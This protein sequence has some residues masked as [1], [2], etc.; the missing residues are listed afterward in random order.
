[1]HLA[2]LNNSVTTAGPGG[3]LL[4]TAYS[5][6]TGGIVFDTHGID[7]MILDK[8]GY[9]GVGTTSPS[10]MVDIVS[11]P[12]WTSA[13]W[14]KSLRFSNGSAMEWNAGATKF[15]IGASS[16]GNALY[17]FTTS[18]D[19]TSAPPDYKLKV[20]SDG[21]VSAKVLEITGGDLAEPFTISDS[22]T[23][24][25][26]AVVVIDDKNPGELRLSST[27]YDPRVAGI[28]SGAGGISAGIVMYQQGASDSTQHVAMAGRAY[29]LT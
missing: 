23:L 14:H 10:A 18:A 6:T 29:A 7:R 25:A 9:L 20:Y 15:G 12:S 3:L 16:S 19:D 2:G 17:V 5:S 21:R 28:V 4:S 24:P 1:M 11:G 22:T 13:N 8:N 27:P 26:G